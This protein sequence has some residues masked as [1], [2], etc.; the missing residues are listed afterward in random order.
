MIRDTKH[1]ITI[2]IAEDDDGHAELIEKHLRRSGIVNSIIRTRDG[3]DT[4]DRVYGEGP[5]TQQGP[6]E[7]FILLLDINMPKLSGPDVLRK[8]RSNVTTFRVP[9]FMLTTTENPVEIQHCYELGCNEYIVKPVDYEVFVETI[10]RLGK[11]LQIL[12]YP[13]LVAEPAKIPHD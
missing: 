6:L 8:I 12:S 13:R 10:T 7:A 1:I 2:L 9:V 5:Y 4:L 3:Q 11:F